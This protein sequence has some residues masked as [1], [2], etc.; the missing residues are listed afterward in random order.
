MKDPQS[1]S[2]LVETLGFATTAVYVQLYG[3]YRK[4]GERQKRFHAG[5]HWVRMPYGD[6]PRMFPYLSESPVS[7][8]LEKLEDKGLPSTVHHDHLS[9][10]AMNQASRRVV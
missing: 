9:W 7:K 2:K 1:M 5:R 4:Q 6:S 8:A 3:H 10:Y